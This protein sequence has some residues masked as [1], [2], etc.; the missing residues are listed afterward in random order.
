MI[1]DNVNDD[2]KDDEVID[3]VEL[4]TSVREATDS[5]LVVLSDI[6]KT[7]QFIKKQMKLLTATIAK[8]DKE[9]AKSVKSG[10]D[11]SP[12]KTPKQHQ[13]STTPAPNHQTIAEATK[14]PKQHQQNTLTEHQKTPSNTSIAPTKKRA[15][16]TELT[17]TPK[18]HQNNTKITPIKEQ[19]SPFIVLDS[20]SKND[21]SSV[22]EIEKSITDAMHDFSKF[23]KDEKGRLRR[24]D[25]RYASKD[26]KQQYQ[27]TAQDVAD[28][29][30]DEKN[31]K[32]IIAKIMSGVASATKAASNATETDAV[33]AGGSAVGGTYFY[34]IK[35]VM[36]LTKSTYEK[37]KPEDEDNSILGKAKGFISKKFGKDKTSKTQQ[38]K[39][40]SSQAQQREIL[41]E[42]TAQ[43]AKDSATTHNKLDDVVSAVK[44]LDDESILDD[45]AD[46]TD[47]VD[48][49][50]DIA[51]NFSG[52]GGE[53]KDKK[54]KGKGQKNR[55][56][57]GNKGKGPKIKGGS[58]KWNKPR[59]LIQ[60]VAN[61]PKSLLKS[62]GSKV[63]GLLKGGMGAG[64]K[65]LGAMSPKSLMKAGG[66]VA[67]LFAG[68]DKFFE[69]Q[70]RD[71]LTT[72]QKTAQV[73][74]TAAGAGAGTALGT[75]LGSA[76]GTLIL[77]GIGTAVGG[78]IGG[79]I[80]G[81]AGAE[82]GSDIGETFSDFLGSDTSLTDYMS[83]A[84]TTASDG[85]SSVIDSVSETT[86]NMLDKASD[87]FDV[88][89]DALLAAMG[90]L[91]SLASWALSDD[92]DSKGNDDRSWWDRATGNKEPSEAKNIASP[93]VKIDNGQSIQEIENRQAIRRQSSSSAD[94]PMTVA[95]D[96]KS[97]AALMA[98]AGSS[99][100]VTTNTSNTTVNKSISRAPSSV[101][102]DFSSRELR[103]QSA[104]L[105]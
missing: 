74:T 94:K 17:K 63:G 76:I 90:P 25:G 92:D 77:P 23:W 1:S 16:E 93:N 43:Q 102:D 49:A 58:T 24:P 15:G 34:A 42:Q 20:D 31:S 64:K 19:N 91:G 52:E 50:L 37:M 55:R 35:E 39:A 88:A 7:M 70:D 30:K 2:T 56:G 13:I 60:R 3:I 95:L 78:F 41:Q 8:S 86:D 45:I 40:E 14:A 99:A 11:N 32:P 61:G 27:K 18:Q 79:A 26:E 51:D 105:E 28:E 53:S 84:W 67:A 87:I 82:F 38:A 103:R 48:D 46:M 71:D 33:E 59:S 69:M 29:R 21:A 62:G 85:A 104:D 100:N 9:L 89:G 57:R 81:G 12:I 68:A 5:E 54:N 97:M 73:A 66:P 83:D 47:F 96:E 36:D 75:T 44:G 22:G 72:E 6:A 10:S 80:G 65:L 101:P 98:V 4:L